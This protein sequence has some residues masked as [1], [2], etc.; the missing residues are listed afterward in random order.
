MIDIVGSTRKS[1]NHGT[2]YTVVEMLGESPD[3]GV[4]CSVK[5]KVLPEELDWIKVDHFI[6][7]LP[8]S[9]ILRDE[10]II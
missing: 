2:I 7:F 6:G 4:L 9:Q 8:L 3:E 10:V 1:I 5:F